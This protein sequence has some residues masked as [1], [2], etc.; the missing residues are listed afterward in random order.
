MRLSRVQALPRFECCAL[1]R[2]RFKLCAIAY[3]VDDVVAASVHDVKER[4]SLVR[5]AQHLAVVCD[6]AIDALNERARSDGD[7]LA[8]ALFVVCLHGVST[9]A[10]IS[11]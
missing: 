11:E 3:F 2:Q 5:A 8:P 9:S 1:S 7:F 6:L 4:L 10:H